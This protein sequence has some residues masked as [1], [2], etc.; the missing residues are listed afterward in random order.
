LYGNAQIL[1]DKLTSPPKIP[2]V[3]RSNS[4]V[5]LV[6]LR[7][8]SSMTESTA[9]ELDMFTSPAQIAELQKAQL[10]TLFALSHTMFDATE[11]LVDL[12][13][14]AVK[15][16]MSES[17][18]QAAALMSARDV[19]ELVALSGS[20]AQPSMEK[21]VSYSRTV[22]GIASG[23]GAEFSRIVETQIAE[24]N[25][26]ATDL[27]EF[28]VKNAPQGSE[29]AVSA[30]KSAVAAANTA[31]D[32]FTK[33]TKQAVEMVENNVAAATSATI[34]ATAAANDVVKGKGKKAA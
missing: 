25:R 1:L 8:T 17:A 24:G 12:N 3:R 18:E 15:A 10:D 22:Y 26:K 4:Q 21:L 6:S 13:L 30:F 2:F 32:T 29:P 28:A 16:T 20:L 11:K 5:S 27:V 9:Q 34:K 31:Y 14:A 7:K 19:Q 33:A 23:A